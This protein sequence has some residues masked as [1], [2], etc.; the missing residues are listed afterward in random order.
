ML[1]QFHN[2]KI[3]ILEPELYMANETI[4]YDHINTQSGRIFFDMNEF[5]KLLCPPLG[6]K[7]RDKVE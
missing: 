7:I 2:W 4:L 5:T 6:V 3:F 1:H